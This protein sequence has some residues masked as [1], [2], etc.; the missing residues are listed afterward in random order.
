MKFLNAFISKAVLI[1]F[2]FIL[3]SAVG[4]LG[5]GVAEAGAKV[6]FTITD[7]EIASGKCIFGGYYH[8]KGNKL[9]S[10]TA[11]DISGTVKNSEGRTICALDHRIMDYKT[12]VIRAGETKYAAFFADTIT[13]P[14]DGPYFFTGNIKVRYVD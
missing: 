5:N 6:E 9:A 1:L 4:F 10:V 7:I 11:F 13:V 8:N 2:S 3:L 14:Y 12:G